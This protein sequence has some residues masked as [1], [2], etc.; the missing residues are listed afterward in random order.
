LPEALPP[1]KAIAVIDDAG[2]EAAVGQ[3]MFPKGGG[4]EHGVPHFHA[5]YAGGRASFSV[6]DLTVLE[7]SLPAR[8]E[9]LVRDWAEEHRSELMSNWQRARAGEPLAK[10]E[11][12]R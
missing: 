10:I 4:K 3:L 9:R 11:P 7:G 2:F 12:L 1:S 6:A 8:A 5:S